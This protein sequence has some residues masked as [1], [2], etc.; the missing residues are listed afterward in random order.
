MDR[1]L[2]L[3]AMKVQVLPSLPPAKLCS[4]LSACRAGRG[5]GPSCGLFS[6][7]QGGPTDPPQS[8][9]DPQL[10]SSSPLTSA[11]FPCSLSLFYTN[12]P[13]PLWASS[14]SCPPTAGPPAPCG[15]PKPLPLPALLPGRG[16]R[17]GD[18]WRLGFSWARTVASP[19]K[20]TA[21]D[22]T[23]VWGVDGSSRSPCPPWGGPRGC[24]SQTGCI[25]S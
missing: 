15:Y 22:V 13:P 20:T 4:P 11:L 18:A 7:Q 23:A 3:G 21:R 16:A 17:P 8:P 24:P 19:C 2:P 9:L 5:W 25:K 1:A 12:P 6:P 14:C 10:T